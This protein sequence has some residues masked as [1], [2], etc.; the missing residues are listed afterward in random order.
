MLSTGLAALQSIT[1]R[2]QCCTRARLLRASMPSAAASDNI[3]HGKQA[4]SGLR[5]RRRVLE[6]GK[7]PPKPFAPVGTNVAAYAKDLDEKWAKAEYPDTWETTGVRGKVVSVDNKGI[8][9]GHRW[10]ILWDGDPKAEPF[11]KAEVKKFVGHEE[12][13]PRSED[14][15]ASS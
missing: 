6:E 15:G 1:A 9:S 11:K 12:N 8:E 2:A 7:E 4:R 10:W 14:E 13:Q 3:S 5:G